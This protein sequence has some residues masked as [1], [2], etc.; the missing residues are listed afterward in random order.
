[1]MNQ[2]TTSSTATMGHAASVHCRKVK[3]WPVDSRSMPMASGARPPPSS[4]AMPPI[5]VPHAIEMKSARP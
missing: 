1:M 3:P 5:C 4:V 2:P